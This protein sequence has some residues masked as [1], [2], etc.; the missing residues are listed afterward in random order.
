M[1]SGPRL[2]YPNH[3]Q[4]RQLKGRGEFC[5]PPTRPRGEARTLP[6]GAGKLER[7]QQGHQIAKILPCTCMRIRL[8][9]IQ[10]CFKKKLTFVKPSA[11]D[12]R[13]W[14]DFSRSRPKGLRIIGVGV[15]GWMDPLLMWAAERRLRG[16]V[17]VLHLVRRL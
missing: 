4:E 10:L 9:S 5:L 2:T 17:Q 14:E 8:R 3:R 12:T 16:S 6:W 15:Q 13:A 1:S 7:C 11:E